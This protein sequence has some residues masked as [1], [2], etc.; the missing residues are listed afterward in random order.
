VKTRALSATLAA[1]AFILPLAWLLEARIP[2]TSRRP[3]SHPPPEARPFAVEIPELRYLRVR[4]GGSVHR[5][6]LGTRNIPD[7]AS[8]SAISL[9]VA[10]FDTRPV[11]DR[12]EIAIAGTNCVYRTPRG[13]RFPNNE[14]LT[15]ERG[16]GCARIAAGAATELRLTVQ[17]D[18]VAR[19]ALWSDPATDADVNAGAIVVSD[20]TAVAPVPRPMLRGALIDVDPSNERPRVQL[21]A[22][23]WQIAA[24]PRWIWI[25]LLAAAALAWTG[26]F[27]L[28][29]A[30]NERAPGWIAQAGAGGFCA[31]AAVTLAYA[32]L[33][34]PFQSADETHHVAGFADFAGRPDIAEKAKELARLGHFERLQF[35]SVEHFT[36]ADIGVPWPREG[37]FAVPDPALRG[38]A[39]IWLWRAVPGLV[40]ALPVP[41]LLLALRLIDGALF[42][43]AVGIFFAIVAASTRTRC[44]ELSAIPLFLVPTLPFFAMTVSNY[45]LLIAAY[46]LMT[47]G[48]LLDFRDDRGAAWAGPL[49]GFGWMV[50]ALT[51]RSAVPLAP[52]LAAWLLGRLLVGRRDSG[53]RPALVYWLGVSAFLVAGVWL[54]DRGYV[55]MTV[56]LGE[57]TLSAILV[58]TVLVVLAH[59]WLL[60]IA[61]LAAAAIERAAAQRRPT[62]SPAL[63]ARLGR[64]AV[65]APLVMIA[66]L[67]LSLVVRYP[68]LA[69]VDP[70][71]S[72]PPGEYL[73]S[74]MAVAVTMFRLTNVD[75]LTSW[76]FWGGFGWLETVPPA[77]VV[78]VLVAASGLAFSALVYRLARD[79]DVRALPRV[80]LALAGA[81]ASMA[82]YALSVVSVTPADLH[83]RYL[84]GL[85][86]SM[87]VIAWSVMPRL[88][89]LRP[90]QATLVRTVCAAACVTVHLIALAVILRRYF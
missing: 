54:A 66:S 42:A 78:S 85:Y 65:A 12:A 48:I 63:R 18:N 37:D 4:G 31:A 10:T 35:R 51:A 23:V 11:L 67:V 32:V 90:T 59:P 16:S 84:I 25:A 26:I 80:T 47:A 62:P 70:F 27:L 19:A 57:Q 52:F 58:R 55:R 89:A 8:R 69:F 82:A 56:G 77:A 87:L 36:P 39:V 79:G 43:V 33:V 2:A 30:P 50:G 9:L 5:I 74:V 49:I 17:F 83:G 14:L 38:A 75:F 34:P 44:P 21:L 3:L 7:L 68:K 76:S 73:A 60:L 29:G 88:A 28:A 53:W 61:G 72:P 15:F 71:K 46:V 64:V 22:Y 45:G 24:S 81:A 41:R 1:I 86:L 6:R 20:R 13:A 40:R